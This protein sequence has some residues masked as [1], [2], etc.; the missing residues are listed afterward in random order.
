M[1]NLELA[2]RLNSGTPP[3]YVR[4][5]IV[6]EAACRVLYGQLK[7]NETMIMK[8]YVKRVAR[9]SGVGSSGQNLIGENYENYEHRVGHLLELAGLSEYILGVVIGDDNQFLYALLCHFMDLL[10]C[11]HLLEFFATH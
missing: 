7:A 11:M 1:Y 5:P 8:I 6:N 4:M 9:E 3:T 2:T 10:L